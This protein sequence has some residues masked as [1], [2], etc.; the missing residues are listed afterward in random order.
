MVDEFGS[1]LGNLDAEAA[2]IDQ[3]ADQS[4]RR[5]QSALDH[6]KN[7]AA[8]WT[9]WPSFTARADDID[10]RMRGFAQSIADTVNDTE[11]A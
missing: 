6:S 5:G 3:S 1:M 8:P 2:N 10:G 7:A 9:R 4:Q 11:R